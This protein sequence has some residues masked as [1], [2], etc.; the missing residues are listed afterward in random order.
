MNYTTD[1]REFLTDML[2]TGGVRAVW[3]MR[4]PQDAGELRKTNRPGWPIGSEAK[5]TLTV[6]KRGRA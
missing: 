5:A 4:Y 3:A 2:A 6:M 1:P